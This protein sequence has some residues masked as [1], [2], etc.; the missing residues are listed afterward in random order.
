MQTSCLTR[1]RVNHCRV[2]GRIRRL[3][4]LRLDGIALPQE[5]VIILANVSDSLFCGE[6]IVL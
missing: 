3:G 4:F 6:S 5:N 1:G 2:K